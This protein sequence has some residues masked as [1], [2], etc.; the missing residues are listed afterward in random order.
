MKT[1]ATLL[2]ILPAMI[3]AQHQPIDLFIGTYTNN[4]KSKG[5]YVYAFDPATGSA[6]LRSTAAANNPSFLAISADR[7]YI[8]AANEN[9]DGEGAVSA[10]AY[11]EATGRL[12]LLNQQLTQGDAPCHVAVDRGGTHVVVSN[13]GGGSISVFPIEPDGS[14]GAISQLI[15]HTGSGPDQSRQQAPHV[16]SAFF[17]PDERRIYV[18]DLGTDNVHIYDFRPAS[19]D[20]PLI[21]A[22]QPVAKS[23]PGG[24]PR[25]LTQ[26]AD[27]KFVYLIEEMIANVLVY[28]QQNG[29]LEAIQEVEINEAG[30][31]GKNGAADIKLSPDGRFLYASNRGD[32]NTLA[33]YRVNATDGTLT[34]V[35]N[36]SVLGRG[37]RN[38][39]ISPD[40]KYLLVANQN[41]DEVVVF[42]RDAATGLL[43]DTGHRIAVGSPVCLV[44]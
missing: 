8:Y 42:S 44:F 38:F 23:S 24:G 41:T 27:G 33:I 34:K 10:Y 11:D 32:A 35:G 6:T 20:G 14:L 36:Q 18:Q 9:G 16:H 19:A 29:R 26:S 4:G 31:T 5:I 3:F 21:P 12:S 15:Q 37:P 22:A 13:Y 43:Q 30:F 25:H 1:L 40:G 17:T 28:R 2:I 39:N 7:K